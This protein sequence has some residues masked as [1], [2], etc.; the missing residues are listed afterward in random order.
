MS[1]ESNQGVERMGASRS[2][3]AQFGRPWR[4]APT[5]HTCRSAA[6]TFMKTKNTL[7]ILAAFTFLVG[8]TPPHRG[9]AYG[10]EQEFRRQLADSVPVKDWGFKIQ[11]IRFSEDYYKALILFAVPGKTNMQETVLENDGFRRYKGL[12]YDYDKMTAFKTNKLAD[13]APALQAASCAIT[14]TIPSK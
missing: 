6:F 12:T 5:A 1:I 8:C 10:H 14:V 3:Q 7:G 2:G 9:P 13:M 4:L 11:D